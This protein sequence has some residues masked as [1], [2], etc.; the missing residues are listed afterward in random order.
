[1]EEKR[2]KEEEGFFFCRLSLFLSLLKKNVFAFTALECSL[3]PSVHN[4]AI[5]TGRKKAFPY[6]QITTQALNLCCASL[7]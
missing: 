1:M 5:R 7:K 4:R 6:V 3:I 2:E